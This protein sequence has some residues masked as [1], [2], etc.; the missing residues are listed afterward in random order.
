MTRVTAT[1]LGR[2]S[3][4]SRMGRRKA[5]VFPLPVVALA[6]TSLPRKRNPKRFVQGRE[7]IAGDEEKGCQE[8]GCPGTSV[9]GGAWVHVHTV[10]VS[11]N[12]QVVKTQSHVTN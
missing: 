8:E 7:P 2:Y 4:L 10:D 9:L 5:A 11:R 1:F 6:H 12:E 3:S